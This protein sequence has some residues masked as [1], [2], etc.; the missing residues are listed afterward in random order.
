MDKRRSTVGVKLSIEIVS[1][2]EEEDRD[3]LSG[4]AIMTLAIA[5]HEMAKARFPEMFVDQEDGGD[6][7]ARDEERAPDLKADPFPNRVSC[8]TQG[9]TPTVDDALS[10]GGKGEVRPPSTRRDAERRP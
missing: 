4:V 3:L 6:G 9:D 5:N 8:A 7:D 2:L 10:R 1:P